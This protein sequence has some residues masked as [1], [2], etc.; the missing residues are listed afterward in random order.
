MRPTVSQFVLG[1]A[2]A[3]GM[4]LAYWRGRVDADWDL[5]DSVLR[6]DHLVETSAAAQSGR[7]PNCRTYQH[8]LYSMRVRWNPDI[9]IPC[10]RYMCVVPKHVLLRGEH[11]Q[12][13]SELNASANLSSILTL[14]CFLE[15]PRRL[16]PLHELLRLGIRALS[17]V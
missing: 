11:H 13:T 8:A 10:V 3:Q 12:R 7:Y 2:F 1:L 4:F 6:E 9:H 5:E 15:L 17:V 16:V 14:T